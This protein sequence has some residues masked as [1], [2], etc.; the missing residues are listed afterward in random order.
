MSEQVIQ[1]SKQKMQQALEAFDRELA[2]I[3]TGRAAPSL[4][5]NISV[6]AYGSFMKLQE[7]ASITAPEASL[8]VVQPWD[9]SIA[10]AIANALRNSDFHFNPIVEGAVIRVPLPPLTQ[11]RRQELVKLVGKKAEEAKI[12]IR[13]IRQDALAQLKRAKDD[14]DI[15]QDEQLGYEK[16]VQEV[17]ENSNRQIEAA[18]KAKEQDLLKI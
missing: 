12:S 5:E 3:R 7:V 8:L 2:S 6:E 9:A 1:Q 17:V 18:A 13:N 11:E 14:G 10:G 16:R 4:I 15:S